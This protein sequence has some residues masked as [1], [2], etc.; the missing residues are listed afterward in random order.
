M[1]VGRE[2]VLIG[3]IVFNTDFTGMAFRPWMRDMLGI[4][5][6]MRYTHLHFMRVANHPI[7]Q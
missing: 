7:V 3:G 5:S 2:N 4:F 1:R 6:E